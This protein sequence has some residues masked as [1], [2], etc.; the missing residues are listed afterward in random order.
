MIAKIIFRDTEKG[1]DIV[2]L[3]GNNY[4]KWQIHYLEYTR[5]FKQLLPIKFETCEQKWTGFGLKW[6]S[7]ENIQKE[8]DEVA[9]QHPEERGRIYST[10]SFTEL[11]LARLPFGE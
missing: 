2:M 8:M 7:E 3:F 6:C 10:F 9:D 4:K 11:S 5:M 1:E